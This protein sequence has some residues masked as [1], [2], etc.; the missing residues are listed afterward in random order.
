MK[1]GDAKNRM[2]QFTVS[3][4][5]DLLAALDRRAAAE[6]ES[7]SAVV[8]RVLEHILRR[9]REEDDVRRYIEG[10]RAQPQTEEEFGWQDAVAVEHLARIPWS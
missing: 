6:G 4:P 7:R 1:A 5:A 9:S 3:V 8:R 10:Y 2:S